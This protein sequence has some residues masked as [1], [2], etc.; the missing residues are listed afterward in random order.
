MSVSI[1]S[2]YYN[3]PVSEVNSRLVLAQ[4]RVETQKV[5]LDS[6]QHTLIGGETLDQLAKKYYGREELWWRI[7]DANVFKHP[8]EW[9]AG[10]V[11]VIPPLRVATRTPLK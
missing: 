1:Y 10:D 7:A 2:R 11:V 3:L 6:I 9:K 5:Y 4:R 8:L